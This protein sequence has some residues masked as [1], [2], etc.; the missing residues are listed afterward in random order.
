MNR[1]LKIML[2]TGAYTGVGYGNFNYNLSP[3]PRRKAQLHDLYGRG[4]RYNRMG[5]VCA[6]RPCSGPQLPK[7]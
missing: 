2:S 7:V 5:R 3:V 6:Y 1:C 4:E